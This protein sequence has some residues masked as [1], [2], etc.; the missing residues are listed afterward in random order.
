MLTDSANAQRAHELFDGTPLCV[1]QIE[2]LAQTEADHAALA[3]IRE[4]ATDCDPL[5]VNF[6]SGSTGTPKGVV[7]CHRSVLDFIGVFV[8]TFGIC[9]QD[10]IANQAPFDFDVSVKDIYSCLLTGATLRIVPRPFFSSP[11]AAFATFA[12]RCKPASC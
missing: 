6:T 12:T 7:V 4:G 9:E 10:R 11:T 2:D 1:M 5:Y 8:R 3:R